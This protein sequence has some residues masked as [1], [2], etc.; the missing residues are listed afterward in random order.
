MYICICNAVTDRD[1]KRAVEDGACS[2]NC[3][4]ETLAVSTCCGQCAENATAC[5]E[6]ALHE[7]Q[8]S[9]TA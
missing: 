9:V 4:Q 6:R 2:L 8:S 7:T 5:L 3:L 1:I